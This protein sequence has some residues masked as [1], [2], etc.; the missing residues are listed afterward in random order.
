LHIE[1]FAGCGLE[2]TPVD[3]FK[4]KHGD[5]PKHLVKPV[6]NIDLIEQQHIFFIVIFG[7]NEKRVSLY[8]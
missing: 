6:V 1:L 3:L 4:K 7:I 2:F 5:S 8:V